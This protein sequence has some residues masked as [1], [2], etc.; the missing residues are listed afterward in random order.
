MPYDYKAELFYKSTQAF[1][2]VF[3]LGVFL[4]MEHIFSRTQALIGEKNLSKLKSSVVAVLGLGGVGGACAEAL[5]RAG[6]GRLILLDNDKFELTNLNRQLF[7]TLDTVDKSK[8]EAA[9]ERLLSIN[10]RADIEII[11]AFYSDKDRRIFD[12]EPDFIADAIDTVSA[13]LDLIENAKSKN[14]NIISCMGTGNRLNPAKFT[15]GDISDTAGC[16]CGLAKVM[17]RELKKRNIASLDVVY[18]TEPPLGCVIPGENTA[19]HA[20]GSISYCPPVAGY[21]MAGF[22]VNS[23]ISYEN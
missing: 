20:P 5:C 14:I 15:V 2:C 23:I 7:A 17:R 21:I 10:S 19:K 12:Y 4:S 3:I 1:A 18:S 6:V 13:K 22:I 9:K 8:C 16:G 11:P